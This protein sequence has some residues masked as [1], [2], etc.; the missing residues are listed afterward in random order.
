MPVPAPPI[1]KRSF[2]ALVAQTEQLLQ[3]YSD[4][5]ST[6]NGNEPGRA[7]V[8]IFAR[9][10]ELVI[11]R[12]NR[13]P[14]KNF[15]AFLDLVGLELLAPQPAR[16]PLTFE[17]AAGSTEDALVPAR[18]PVAALPAEGEP[19]PIVFETERE[20]VVTR[21]QLVAAFTRE[22]GRDLYSDHAAV[23]AGQV[24]NTLPVFQ[25]D[26][27]IAHQIY[28]GHSALFG[29]DVAKDITLHMKPAEG[30]E[31]WLSAVEWSYWK[32]T[33][34]QPLSTVS[35]P[36][37]VDDAWEVT[38]SNVPAIPA[39]TV[40]GQTSAWVRGRLHTPLPRGELIDVDA[41]VARTDLRQQDL[42]ADAGFADDV[43]LDFSQ[44]FYP[45][46]EQTPRLTFYLASDDAF[47][48]PGGQ[49]EINIDVDATRPARPSTD[50]ILDWEYWDGT[51]WQQLGRSSPTSTSLSSS[52]YEFTDATQALTRDGA[53][54]F[55][56]PANW[57]MNTVN[58]ASGF[59]LRAGIATGSYGP[60]TEYTPPVV[61]RLALSYTWPLPRI[62][63]TRTRV[64][65]VGTDRPL[66]AVF[67]DQFAVDSTKD[68]F[69]FGEKP[70]VGTAL[71]L[72]SEEAFSKP[73]AAIT[74]TVRLTNP[75]DQAGIPP[76]A[77]PSAN[78]TLRWEF[79]DGQQ[80][81]WDAL[82]ESGPGAQLSPQH[83][84]RDET[85]AFVQDGQQV[86]FSC[87]ETLRPVDVNGQLRPWLRVRIVKGDYGREAEYRLKN[88]QDPEEGYVL[89]PAT[90][91]PP[92]IQSIMI[93][94]DYTSDLTTPDYTMADNDFVIEDHSQAAATDGALFNPYTPTTDTH[95]TFY[96][97]FQR[98][99]ADTGFANRSTALYFSVAEVPY[100]G[101]R[102][103][104]P[105]L[106][107]PAAVVWEYWNGSS[108]GRLGTRDE[109]QGFTQRGLVTFIGPPNFRSSHA[110]DRT[111][112]W[113]RARWERGGYVTPPQLHRVLTNTIWAAHTL[114]VQNELLGAGNGEPNQ[115]FRT[116]KT[117]VLQG[118]AIE[119]R[120]PEMPSSAERAVIEAE[121]GQD[122]ITTIESASREQPAEIWVRWHQVP[123]FHESDPRSRHYTLD[124]LTGEI[125]F[126][127]GRHG[128]VL[129]QGRANVRATR[130]QSGGGIQG[131]QPA[132][133]LTQLKS[134]IPYVD[135]VTNW[136]ASGGGA[137]QETLEA[138]KNRGPKTLRHRNRAVAIVDFEE[139]AFEA[140]THV[141]RVKG[142]PATGSE[143]AGSVG[144]VIVPRS[145][146]PQ[147]I[148]SLELLGRVKD[149]IEAHLAPTVD[150]W[151]EG[152][153]W[154][155]VIVT[156]EIVP[157]SLE[158]AT[159]VQTAVMTSLATF[160]HPLTGGLDGQGWAFG[161]KPY[162]SDLYAL[163]ESTP[164]VDHVRQL[165]VA[166]EGNVRPARFLVYSGDHHI[167]L[168]GGT[169]Q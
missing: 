38:L 137:A 148:P 105:S 24:D 8:R 128:L 5:R 134:A 151:V 103:E 145:T 26:R 23:I 163:I 35:P 125:R 147:P 67:T 144:V 57:L 87:P 156:A 80:G 141:A 139:L 116:A 46:G 143:D 6:A 11:D 39:T 115:V 112:F 159:D 119:V 110:F 58:D 114:T 27:P 97:G 167:T 79:W 18:T 61:S 92:S 86:T 63:R 72:A 98:P 129:P 88:S 70:K 118:Q 44:P 113:L 41:G 142:I 161:R 75:S 100:E 36:T 93:S 49:V 40:G 85:G 158:A 136:E 162:R 48:K 12:L 20:L 166:E 33:E 150:L 51:N 55:R 52:P 99:G 127:D 111:A 107:E 64:H 2:D 131:N 60:S 82:G 71:Y 43:H 73:N 4:W 56:C 124:R 140:S 91:R 29:I 102:P 54:T 94:Y 117:P 19:E 157:V 104:A 15:L 34:W 106:A 68:F 90:F 25:G 47:S 121:E 30:A 45:F 133:T 132:G 168:I 32:G 28:L 164:G 84:F 13:V 37:R 9:L 10:A 83:N 17:L 126:G 109:T 1:D 146:A 89:V 153:D 101:S 69:P 50:L 122:V 138:I 42:A 155:Q 120:E 78:L 65:I 108:W 3:Y 66:D 81:T 96:L 130:Y 74:L 14:D 77:G 16:V 165:I 160:L 169:G 59:W 149:H 53:V 7:L 152:P 76:P 22:P 154:L 62:D 123:D 135:S 31:S 95:P 21:S